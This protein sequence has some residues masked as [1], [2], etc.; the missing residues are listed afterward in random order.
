MII[1]P[2]IDLKDGKCVRLLQGDYSQ[3]K[4]YFTNPIDQALEWQDSGAQLIHIVDLDGAKDGTGKNYKII[5]SI[6]KSIKIP[7]EV[8][9]GIRDIETVKYL[10][11]IGV[12]YLVIGTA[13]VKDS[14]FLNKIIS[15]Y[16]ENITVGI[17]AKNNYIATDGWIKNT[18][19]DY[20][21]FS[22]NIEK[23]G[24]K[25][26]IYT[27]ISRDGMMTSPNFNNI[28][29]LADTVKCDII[30]SGGVSSLAD[31]TALKQSDRNNIKGVIIGKAL[32]EKRFTLKEAI[33][34]IL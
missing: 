28:K 27:D 15:C 29:L 5:E 22:Q 17:D 11:G 3:S 4:Q 16:Q 8:G 13:A 14:G 31:L 2:A 6:I 32:Y 20:L 26:I 19:L 21:Q 1:I 25:R 12:K 9:G 10:I 24:C 33:K 34:I 7:V 30:A 23:I 18:E